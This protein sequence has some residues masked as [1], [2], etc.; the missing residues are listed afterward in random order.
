MNDAIDFTKVHSR[1][2]KR[3]K[4]LTYI[5]K[6]PTRYECKA[7]YDNI[8]DDMISCLARLS[9][10]NLISGS[11]DSRIKIWDAN[12]GQVHRELEGHTHEITQI[13]E[14]NNGNIASASQDK[15]INVWDRQSAEI[16]YTLEGF[17]EPIQ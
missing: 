11:L 15:T 2:S 9:N 7:T 1:I 16:I 17:E 6:D 4:N 5:L 8:H 3:H 14:L 12:T 13:I 10:G